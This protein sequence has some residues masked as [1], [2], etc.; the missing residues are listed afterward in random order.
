[1]RAVPYW[2]MKSRL[3]PNIDNRAPSVGWVPIRSVCLF[4]AK[5]SPALAC[6]GDEI[7][8]RG[9]HTPRGIQLALGLVEM[10]I[11]PNKASYELLFDG[12]GW[13]V[14]YGARAQEKNLSLTARWRRHRTI[15]S[16]CVTPVKDATPRLVT[17]YHVS[18]CILCCVNGK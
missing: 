2:E 3:S 8:T 4:N 13:A 18:R 15:E 14:H 7:P 6:A 11:A 12:I 17:P 1:M 10:P 9:S 16:D 5:T